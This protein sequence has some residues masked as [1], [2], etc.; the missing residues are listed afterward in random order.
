MSLGLTPAGHLD[1]DRELDFTEPS[2]DELIDRVRLDVKRANPH[3]E[4]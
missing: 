4:E 1:H 3:A 2:D